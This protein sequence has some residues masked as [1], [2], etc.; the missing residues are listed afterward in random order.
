MVKYLANFAKVN[1]V[2]IL[3]NALECLHMIF[4]SFFLTATILQSKQLKIEYY[5]SNESDN[6]EQEIGSILL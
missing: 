3:R 2:N 5:F 4:V 1:I 6:E